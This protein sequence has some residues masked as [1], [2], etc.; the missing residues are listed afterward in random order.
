M[1]SLTISPAAPCGALRRR[2]RLLGLGLLLALG[3]CKLIDQTTFAPA[4]GA[5]PAAPAAPTATVKPPPVDPRTPLVTIGAGTAPEDYRALL[6]FA[7]GAAERRDPDVRFDV[8]AL[9]PA[10]SAPQAAAKSTGMTSAP[11]PADAEPPALRASVATATAVMHEIAA[12]GVPA[13]RIRLHAALAADAAQGEVRVY[14][15]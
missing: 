14:V 11:G 8:M 12:A 4:P 6:R 7:V 10:S 5:H 9:A 13:D 15:R 3:G 2:A 1:F